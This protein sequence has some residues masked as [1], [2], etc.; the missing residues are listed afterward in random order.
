VTPRQR[1]LLLTT[2]MVL[3]ALTPAWFVPRWLSVP[4]QVVVLVLAVP[5]LWLTWFHGPWQATPPGDL[6][7]IVG[8][9]GLASGQRFCDL[10]AG[11]GRIVLAVNRATGADCTGFELS[12]VVWAVAQIRLAV[13]GNAHTR[14][15]LADLNGADLTGFDA[16][17]VWGTAYSR[18]GDIV[19]RM[20]PGATLVSYHQPIPGLEA[21]TVD[22]AGER[23]IWVYEVIS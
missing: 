16:V 3:I 12:P 20:R 11:D 23:P 19:G 7:R 9:L 2:V 8:H 17:Y 22:D 4:W 6:A 21:R 10:G 18:L 14:V 13:Q 1:D 15:R 5:A